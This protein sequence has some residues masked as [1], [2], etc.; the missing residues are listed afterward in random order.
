MREV[1]TLLL[2]LLLVRKLREGTAE[3]Q[4][5][6][7]WL[8]VPSERTMIGAKGGRSEEGCRLGL[9]GGG[10]WKVDGGY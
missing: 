3:N 7:D 1:H 10:R 4:V 8:S 5:D 2:H 6:R 9:E